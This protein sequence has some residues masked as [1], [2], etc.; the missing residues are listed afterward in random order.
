MMHLNT[1]GNGKVFVV[2]VS[3]G[4]LLGV[5]WK[6]LLQDSSDDRRNSFS[7]KSR[8]H[9]IIATE[10]TLHRKKPCNSLKKSGARAPKTIE[11]CLDDITSAIEA[12][13]GNA[14]AVELCVNRI[15]GGVT[16]SIGFV[17]ECVELF[18]GTDVEVHVLVRPRPGGFVYTQQ[19]FDVILR[20][21]LTAKAAGVSGV[22]VGILLPDG[23][24]DIERM[25]I[26]RKIS[27]GIQLTFHRAF[28]V[29]AEADNALEVS[30]NRFR[31]PRTRL[32]GLVDH[33]NCLR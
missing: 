14:S 18:Q 6:F 13:A 19:E 2:G 8:P 1:S 7:S 12:K 20:D 21:I 17:E 29:C 16:P 25:R 32:D 11:I 5:V 26:V 3:F 4:L 24:I 31:I 9:D 30:S 22:V 15:E 33:L 23:N 28:D 10:T 27:E